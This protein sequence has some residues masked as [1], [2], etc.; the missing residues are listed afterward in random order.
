M[1]EGDEREGD[2]DR[3]PVRGGAA[4]GTERAEQGLEH[5]RQDRPGPVALWCAGPLL[6][7]SRL[8]RPVLRLMNGCGNG[9]VRLPDVKPAGEVGRVHSAE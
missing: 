6:A 1:Q 4:R 5:P 8:T 3:H 9:L 2:R 7:F